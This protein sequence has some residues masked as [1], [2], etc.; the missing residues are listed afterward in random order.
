MSKSGQNWLCE[1]SDCSCL[2]EVS[3]SQ[4]VVTEIVKNNYNMIVDDCNT[5]LPKG[6]VLIRQCEGG[7]SLYKF[8]DE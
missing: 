1:C 5:P 4:R 7:Y 6:A 8:A 2:L 3:M